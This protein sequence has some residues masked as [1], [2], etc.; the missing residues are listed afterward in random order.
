[1]VHLLTNTDLEG[2]EHL[3]RQNPFESMRSKGSRGDF[4]KSQH[5]S[6]YQKDM[7]VDQL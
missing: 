1:M 2:I 7:H 6:D 5:S 4:Q 3:R